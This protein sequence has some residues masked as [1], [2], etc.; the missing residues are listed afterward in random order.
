MTKINGTIFG[1]YTYNGYRVFRVKCEGKPD[2]Y[3]N[4]DYEPVV[5]LDTNDL[6][7]IK[8]MIDGELKSPSGTPTK[9]QTGV[10]SQTRSITA[11]KLL[12]SDG[13]PRLPMKMRIGRNTKLVDTAINT[14]IIQP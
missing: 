5:V 12:S 4:D 9:R 8:V 6:Q 11:R 1:V 13:W 7:T 14:G 10:R 3:V 2:V